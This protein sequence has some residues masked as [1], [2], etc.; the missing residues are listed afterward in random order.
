[1]AGALIIHGYR[2]PT[3]NKTGDLDLL[4][5]GF[6]ERTL[7]FQQIQYACYD[8]NGKIQTDSKGNYICQNN[9]IGE[10]RDYQGFGVGGWG[11]SGRYTSING[12]VQPF[13]TQAVAG[14]VE[15]WR[16]IMLVCATVLT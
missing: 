11:K 6:K 5:Y 4:T 10:I 3:P 7:V 13:I 8:A 15:R 9:Q 16:M 2:Q 1:M 12:E 14:Q